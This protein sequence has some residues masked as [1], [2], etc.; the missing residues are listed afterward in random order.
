M[1]QTA[2]GDNGLHRS[3]EQA[4]EKPE[5]CGSGEHARDQGGARGGLRIARDHAERGERRHE[6][7]EHH[8]IGER[9]CECRAGVADRTQGAAL[10]GR[11][12]RVEHAPA[13]GGNE[14]NSGGD[15]A[16][17]HVRQGGT[18][19]GDETGA[20]AVDQRP[21]CTHD[22]HGAHGHRH[23]QAHQRACEKIAHHL[24]DASDDDLERSTRQ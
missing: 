11:F 16:P 8:R 10:L 21:P 2:A 5:G 3:R 20:D 12:R 4:Y 6:A 15:V 14:Q 18:E 24:N 19:T 23:E 17:E 22:G 13:T 9:Q 7:D 1:Q